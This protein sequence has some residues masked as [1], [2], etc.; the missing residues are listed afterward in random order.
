MTNSTRVPDK[1][2]AISALMAQFVYFESN[3][4]NFD[5]SDFNV[6]FTPEMHVKFNLKFGQGEKLPDWPQ[7]SAITSG[8]TLFSSKN[9]NDFQALSVRSDSSNK[10]IIALGGSSHPIFGDE[11][12][13]GGRTDWLVNIRIPFGRAVPDPNFDP[14]QPPPQPATTMY[15]NPGGAYAAAIAEYRVQKFLHTFKTYVQGVIAANP[16]AE[17]YCT[18]H[19][20]GGYLCKLAKDLFPDHIKAVYAASSPN[21]DYPS[22]TPHDTSILDLRLLDRVGILPDDVVPE[23]G[24]SK[25]I[26]VYIDA[27]SF[28]I[29]LGGWFVAGHDVNLSTTALL[30]VISDADGTPLPETSAR[31]NIVSIITRFTE[32]FAGEQGRV[33]VLRERD[34][35][36][37][38]EFPEATVN[39]A[40]Q[41][42][43]SL[44]L[45]V[46]GPPYLGPSVPVRLVWAPFENGG[47]GGFIIDYGNARPAYYVTDGQSG[48]VP[49]DPDTGRPVG[50]PDGATADQLREA[51]Y[52]TLYPNRDP[53]T[54]TVPPPVPSAE[55]LQEIVVTRTKLVFPGLSN[56]QVDAINDLRKGPLREFFGPQL[57]AALVAGDKWLSFERLISGDLPP[58]LGVATN[59]PEQAVFRRDFQLARLELAKKFS[60]FSGNGGVPASKAEALSVLGKYDDAT[61]GSLGTHLKTMS[62]SPGDIAALVDSYFPL[63]AI[64]AD[65]VLRADPEVMAALLAAGRRIERIFTGLLGVKFEIT[66]LRALAPVVLPHI[67]EGDMIIPLTSNGFYDPSRVLTLGRTVG[68]IGPLYQDGKYTVVYGNRPA[69]E[70][71][72]EAQ[73]Q[74]YIASDAYRLLPDGTSLSPAEAIIVEGQRGQAPSSDGNGET[75]FDE[76]AGKNAFTALTIIASRIASQQFGVRDPYAAILLNVAVQRA[77]EEVVHT[78]LQNL[79]LIKPWGEGNTFQLRLADGLKTGVTSGLTSLVTSQVMARLLAELGVEGVPADAITSVASSTASHYV[80]HRLGMTAVT[81]AQGQ[82]IPASLR[83]SFSQALESAPA[84]ITA[85]IVI[86]EVFGINNQTAKMAG[87]MAA[88][89]MFAFKAGGPGGIYA[90]AA[91]VAVTVIFDVIG[92]GVDPDGPIGKVNLIPSGGR[93]VAQEAYVERNGFQGPAEQLT[94]VIESQMYTAIQTLNT[95]LEAVDARVT[96]LGSG[97]TGLRFYL[98]TNSYRSIV[99][100]QEKYFGELGVNSLLIN[101]IERTLAGADLFI[102]ASADP[103]VAKALRRGWYDWAIY[104]KSPE[105]RQRLPVSDSVFKLYDAVG[106]TYDRGGSGS[107]RPSRP[108]VGTPEEIVLGMLAA[109]RGAAAVVRATYANYI[110]RRSQNQSTYGI[111]SLDCFDEWVTAVALLQALGEET[112]YTFPAVPEPGYPSGELDND[113]V[114]AYVQERLG[115]VLHWRALTEIPP[116]STGQSTIQPPSA[117]T[118]TATPDPSVQVSWQPVGVDEQV[119]VQWQEEGGLWSSGK[120]ESGG[121]KLMLPAAQPGRT[122]KVQAQ[123]LAAPVSGERRASAWTPIKSVTVPTG[124]EGAQAT[125]VEVSQQGTDPVWTGRDVQI[126]WEGSFPAL[127]G[128]SAL[129]ASVATP[130][131]AMLGYGVRVLDADAGILL[132]EVSISAARSYTY[133]YEDNVL[134]SRRIGR[135]GP[136]RRLRF[137]VSIIPRSGPE[138]G[139]DSLTVHNPAPAKVALQAKAGTGYL[140]IDIAPVTDLDLDGYVVWVSKDKGFAPAA[141]TPVY[142]GPSPQVT[143][144][145]PSTGKWYVRAAAVDMFQPRDHL[146]LTNINLSDEVEVELKELTISASQ[147]IAGRIESTR[148][149]VFSRQYRMGDIV[150]EAKRIPNTPNNLNNLKIRWGKWSGVDFVNG[151]MEID[152]NETGT[153]SKHD[154]AWG[155]YIGTVGTPVYLYWRSPQN[156]FHA[157]PDISNI[158][159]TDV[160]LANIRD[161]VS[162]IDQSGGLSGP[163]PAEL[164]VTGNIMSAGQVNARVMRAGEMVVE[165][166]R[167][168]PEVTSRP[169]IYLRTAE[170][171]TFKRLKSDGTTESL[172]VEQQSLFCYDRNYRRRVELYS[173]EY[174]AGIVI[175]NEL[176]ETIFDSNGF[177]TGVIDERAIRPESATFVRSVIGQPSAT[178]NVNIKGLRPTDT[179][180]IVLMAYGNG[181][182]SDHN[183]LLQVRG[184]GLGATSDKWNKNNPEN[185]IGFRADGQGVFLKSFP[186]SQNKIYSWTCWCSDG[187]STLHGDDFYNDLSNKSTIDKAFNCRVGLVAFVSLR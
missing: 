105:F 177:G 2:I 61:V 175:K 127:G 160:L 27:Q 122:Y 187:Q 66:Q 80:L 115:Q 139:M 101:F 103:I 176:G 38:I 56:S 117:V 163:L 144:T 165:E 123:R 181:F 162:A 63:E 14:S 77:T 100:G 118:L 35:D 173:H 172:P 26:V 57:E 96:S 72:T 39:G 45:P 121:S 157:T 97:R 143:Y 33:V 19:S 125:R 46:S 98:K 158:L 15:P 79:N 153:F 178:V 78:T 138:Q 3:G 102:P 145:A 87:N 140:S 164:S 65:P 41:S 88:S 168:G 159:P 95:A 133:P 58:S 92:I 184:D 5:Q 4:G 148:L 22:G 7:F 147:I 43:Y 40:Q 1:D 25:G 154:I 12:G 131:D 171:T 28:G 50:A 169:G 104:G 75:P 59:D 23:I 70:F 119:A 132:R 116:I 34:G 60:P 52:G 67:P 166:I 85:N 82:A 49:I 142:R 68:V 47:K 108:P 86:D 44:T 13:T 37:R 151:Q 31:A 91:M 112:G 120:V 99:N 149:K 74:A 29:E 9:E 146:D 90:A 69:Q 155:E 62:L 126:N 124:L 109:T 24:T 136:S 94:M 81:N 51:S 179:A 36:V 150:I 107:G 137:E 183:T 110:Q 174:D 48:T 141:M 64:L 16:E 185:Y 71:D 152:P 76:T 156:V 93:F 55:Q 170:S 53:A 30:R 21:V 135:P 8:W 32:N 130:T 128:A 106:K 84:T 161:E 54:A 73:A 186:V 83:G 89:L 129:L 180:R 6:S 182:G 111:G 20:L 18:G 42:A 11:S 167:I 113:N 17:F 10:V 114:P 134:D